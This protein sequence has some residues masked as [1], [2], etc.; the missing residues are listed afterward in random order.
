MACLGVVSGL[1][2]DSGL[3]TGFS[4]LGNSPGKAR[5]LSVVQDCLLSFP[6]NGFIPGESRG[7]W[8]KSALVIGS[9]RR[10]ENDRDH[11]CLTVIVDPGPR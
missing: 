11:R 10:T 7:K 8:R 5:E 3:E 2:S 9:G 1:W 4:G 6:E